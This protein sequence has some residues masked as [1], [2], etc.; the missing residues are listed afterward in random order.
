[1][2]RNILKIF[3]ALL[4]MQLQVIP[5]FARGEV[6]KWLCS[7]LKVPFDA[8]SAIKA[9]PLEKMPDPVEE[10]KTK[11]QDEGYDITWI[12]L[13]ATGEKYEVEYRYAFKSTDVSS[14]YGFSLAVTSVTHDED[15]AQ[16]TLGWL[17]EMG[18]PTWD[19]MVAYEVGAG[20]EIYE[21]SGP[22]FNFAS[23]K[24]TGHYGANWFRRGDLASAPLLCK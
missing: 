15:F 12:S 4:A 7:V 24:L 3:S 16:A 10:R 19:G 8:A 5:A 2:S 13:T 9:F 11:R 18:K 14:P 23:W 21:G 6:N 1:M 22:A 17:K 20:P